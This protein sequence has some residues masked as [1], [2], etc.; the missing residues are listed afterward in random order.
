VWLGQ[1]GKQLPARGG[2]AS[3]SKVGGFPVCDPMPWVGFMIYPITAPKSAV[4]YDA[5]VLVFIPIMQVWLEG[6]TL[7]SPEVPACCAC[8]RPLFLVAQASA[9]CP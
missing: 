1:L 8:G 4:V 9:A 7:G 2:D 6:G 3:E 5:E